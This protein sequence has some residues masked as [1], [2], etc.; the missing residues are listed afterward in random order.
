MTIKMDR[1]G[2]LLNKYIKIMGWGRLDIN[3][4]RTQQ[5]I[6]DEIKWSILQ[7]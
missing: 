6:L 1:Q 2:K 4:A 7:V 5:L 3:E